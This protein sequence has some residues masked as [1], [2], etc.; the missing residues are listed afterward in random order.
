[1][2]LL[3]WE[4]FLTLYP[5][6]LSSLLDVTLLDFL[7]STAGTTLSLVLTLNLFTLADVSWSPLSLFAALVAALVGRL[8]LLLTAENV[9]KLNVT[10]VHKCYEKP[11]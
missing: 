4:E 8:S 7:C 5:L 3:G 2:L 6:L 9:N 11:I 10:N 1:M